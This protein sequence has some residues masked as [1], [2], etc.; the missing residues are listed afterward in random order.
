MRAGYIDLAYEKGAKLVEAGCAFNDFG[1]RRRRS[2]HA[3]DILIGQL[4]RAEKDH[5]G[6]GILLG[7]SNVCY[8]SIILSLPADLIMQVHFSQ[9][10]GL[11]PGGTIGQ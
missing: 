9:K 6:K 3:Q 2:Y 7:T 5:P 1:T 10:Y 11:K 8:T 4:V